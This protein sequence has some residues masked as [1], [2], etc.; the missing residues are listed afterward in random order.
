[1]AAFDKMTT[2]KGITIIEGENQL[3]VWVD[4]THMVNLD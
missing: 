2:D 3:R 4:A 1:M